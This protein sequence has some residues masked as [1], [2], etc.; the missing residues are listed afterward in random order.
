MVELADTWDL[1]SHSFEEYEFKSRYL[2]YLAIITDIQYRQ[3]GEEN[4]QMRP[5]YDCNIV[6]RLYNILASSSMVVASDC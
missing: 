2:H 5:L 1:K 6:A 3:S 4:V